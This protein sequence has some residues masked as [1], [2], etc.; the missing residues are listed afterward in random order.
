M[1]AP[2]RAQVSGS[3]LLLS[4]IGNWPPSIA[5][6]GASNRQSFYDQANL[7][8]GF[9][10]GVLG[11]RFETH[12]NSEEELVYETVTQRFI[13]WSD[14]GARIR[15]GNFYTILGRGLVHRSFEL[16]G[17]VL[18]NVGARSPYG[19][20]RDVDGLLAE[21]E[22]GPLSMRLLSGAPS[23]GTVSP[24][25][26]EPPLNRARHRGQISGGQIAVGLPRE[27]RVG[28]AYSRSKGGFNS[29]TGLSRQQEVGSGFV[30]VDPLRVLQVKGVSLPLYAEYAQKGR[31]FSK[32]W[33]LGLDDNASHALYAGGNLLWGPVGVSAEWKDYRDFRNGTNDPPSLVREHSATLLNRST[34]VIEAQ[35]ED[36]YQLEGSYI[37]IAGLTLLGNLSRSD[38]PSDDRYEERYVEAHATA[39]GDARWEATLFYDWGSDSTQSVLTR[40]TYGALA[41]ARV[42][43]D[44]SATL[45]LQRQTARRKQFDFST[46]SIAKR[47]FENVYVAAG[48]ALANRGSL[49]MVWERTNDDL[50]RS[51]EFGRTK[52]LHLIH[53]VASTRIGDGHEVALTVGKRRGGLACTAGTC[54]EVQPFEGAE[55]RV[56]SRF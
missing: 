50:D 12:R 24:A 36:G 40:H 15:V 55:L 29:T 31:T 7:E 41:T 27:V 2:A 35:D 10:T 6:R 30:E 19:P 14:H 56:A 28:A 44:W 47:E 25:E 9:T 8:Y 51:W 16:T 43:G 46:F 45:D 38:G 53:W 13:D 32:W 21:Y 48:V 1:A 20:S 22:R 23:E 3:N 52:P 54:Y 39:A 37:P 26:E 18:E 5:G 11:L 33:D 17:V 34:H 4:Q 42:R 49:T